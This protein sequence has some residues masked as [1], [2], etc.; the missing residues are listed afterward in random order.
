MQLWRYVVRFGRDIKDM[1]THGHVYSITP[2]QSH[3]YKQIHVRLLL[4]F[5]PTTPTIFN[6]Y[7]S[8]AVLV[9]YG[10]HMAQLWKLLCLSFSLYDAMYAPC[11]F[12]WG[13]R[14]KVQHM[15]ASLSPRPNTVYLM[16]CRCSQAKLVVAAPESTHYPQSAELDISR[17]KC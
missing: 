2:R 15:V 13:M 3:M 14:N 6:I 10:F 5:T 9:Q 17:R 1:Q 12:F 4:T 11:G 16:F 8:A 7:C